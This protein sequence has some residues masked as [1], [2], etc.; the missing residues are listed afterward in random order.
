MSQEQ[1]AGKPELVNDA[2]RSGNGSSLPATME[3]VLRPLASLKL[4]VVLLG[5]A[6]FIVLA[7]TMAQWQIPTWRAVDEYF[8]VRCTSV[9][10]F[11]QTSYVWIDLQIFFPPSFFPSKPEIPRWLGFPFPKGW[12]IGFALAVNLFAA[13]LLRFK[14][15]ARGIRLA[16]GIADRCGRRGGSGLGDCQRFQRERF[17][18]TALAGLVDALAAPALGLDG[19]LRV[20][21]RG[22]VLAQH[23]SAATPRRIPVAGTGAGWRRV[24]RLAVVALPA[25]RR[26]LE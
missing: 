21:C 1:T 7:G 8:R 5:M 12:L 2:P 22:G 4:T 9:V 26:S 6:I 13:H 16:G 19:G 11:F 14:V 24:V 17:P 20:V 23:L 3:S 18:G 15:Q 10:D 25:L